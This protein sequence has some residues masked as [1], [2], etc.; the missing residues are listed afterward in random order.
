MIG[1]LIFIHHDMM[2]LPSEFVSHGFMVI[3]DP[4]RFDQEIVIIQQSHPPFVLVIQRRPAAD[5]L[6]TLHPTR[7]F[8][9][10]D[11]LNIDT[12][13]DR[14]RQP[15]LDRLGLRET[16]VF[17]ADAHEF[18]DTREGLLRIAGVHHRQGP[19]SLQK[20]AVSTQQ[21]K[22]EGVKG[23][24][25]HRSAPFIRQALGAFDHLAG[26]AAGE[27]QQQ[28][29]GGVIPPIDQRGCPVDENP[30]FAAARTGDDE[31]GSVQGLHGFFLSRIEAFQVKGTDG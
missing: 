20:P 30:R 25:P 11:L 31:T 15:F 1:V 8:E 17:P 18:L 2:E 6:H 24:R 27:G 4:E 26:R 12:L 13:V 7:R 22:R 3:E 19:R 21:R 23:A 16:I 28:N 14:R 29:A 10:E 9:P 5:L